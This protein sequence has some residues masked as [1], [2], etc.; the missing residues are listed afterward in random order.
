MTGILEKTIAS[1]GSLFSPLETNAS[2]KGLFEKCIN[3]RTR[4]EEEWTIKQCLRLVR[5]KLSEPN[6]SSSTIAKCLVFVVFAETLGYQA[7]FA[8]IHAVKLAQNGSLIEKKIG[9]LACVC[10][11]KRSDPLTV[12]LVNTILRDISSKNV[13]CISMALTAACSL[14]PTDQASVFLPLAVEKLKHSNEFVRGKAVIALHHFFRTSPE[15]CT[16]YIEQ[17]QELLGDKDPGVVALAMQILLDVA[18]ETPSLVS[19]LVPLLV[20]IQH[21]ILDGKLPP[22]YTYRKMNAPWMQISVLR[23]LQLMDEPTA[24]IR[25]VIHKTLILAKSGSQEAIG[26][27]IICACIAILIKYKPNDDILPTAISHVTD[28]MSRKSNNL[29]YAGLDLLEVIL[30]H[31]PLSLTPE[32]QEIIMSSLQHPDHAVKRKT[33]ALL[34][35]AA[36]ASNAEQICTQ[37]ADYAQTY[38][39]NNIHLRHDLVRRIILL[40]QKYPRDN[41]SWHVAMLLR[42]LPLASDSQV[43]TIHGSIK[44][45]LSGEDQ[46]KNIGDTRQKVIKILHKYSKSKIAVTAILQLYVWVISRFGL[47]AVEGAVNKPADTIKEI[48]ELGHKIIRNEKKRDPFPQGVRD[49]LISIVQS[50]QY[51]SVH[52]KEHA[53]GIDGFLQELLSTSRRDSYLRDICFELKCSLPFVTAI[54]EHTVKGQDKYDQLDF[55]LSFLDEMVCKSLE[56][57]EEP[58]RPPQAVQVFQQLTEMPLPAKSSPCTS[59][60]SS[61]KGSLAGSWCSEDF[62]LWNITR[63]L[64]PNMSP[65]VVW[66]KEGR[67]NPA[68]NKAKAESLTIQEQDSCSIQSS[69]ASSAASIFHLP[70]P[71]ENLS[72][73]EKSNVDPLD[74]LLTSDFSKLTF[75]TL[76]KR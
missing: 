64:S 76:E 18:K 72:V 53:Y 71:E 45:L 13:L 69:E 20:Q 30:Q 63:Q 15:Q 23:L 46:Q 27:A 25:A 49:L 2:L 58:Y 60:I 73:T 47:P 31:C 10:L 38:C 44:N 48:I 66:T 75:N 16:K 1:I 24:D 21:Q 26:V 52:K 29:R 11:L 6:I 39:S 33:L 68:E 67:L 55:T 51:V 65:K 61:E 19:E 28:L 3:A 36:N 57:G 70:L 43:K 42:L 32:Q 8:Y 59:V 12:L 17:V 41:D 22:D 40:T 37:I 7:E 4:V 56:S 14:I 35:V 50:L 34:C 54:H 9:Y 5:E 74:K 62:K